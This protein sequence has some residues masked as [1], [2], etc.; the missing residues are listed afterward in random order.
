MVKCP[1]LEDSSSSSR[2]ISLS[3]FILVP[4][5]PT[6]WDISVSGFL[7]WPLWVCL[8]YSSYPTISV[9][10]GSITNVVEFPFLETFK[11]VWTQSCPTCSSRVGRPDDLLRSLPTCSPSPPLLIVRF[12]AMLLVSI[13]HAVVAD[14][15]EDKAMI[16]LKLLFSENKCCKGVYTHL[17]AD[18]FQLELL[19]PL[20]L[21]C[22][23][24]FLGSA[25]ESKTGW[26]PK[27]GHPSKLIS[28]LKADEDP[29]NY[30][31]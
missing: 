15:P 28:Q 17:T 27:L 21:H 11:T 26:L 20:V 10:Y 29:Q 16:A 9:A 30:W 22:K 12:C 4:I 25:Q 1:F 19:R 3:M 2:E 14:L 5:L 8:N 23:S 6:A 24:E 7:S 13:L 31:L 18:I